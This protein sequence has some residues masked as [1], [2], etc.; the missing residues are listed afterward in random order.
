MIGSNAYNYINVLSKAADASWIRNEVIA[1]NIANNDTAD[2]KRQD[3]VFEL[4]T[5]AIPHARA[6]Q[7]NVIPS[8]R[9][10]KIKYELF[11]AKK[12]FYY[13]FAILY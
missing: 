10:A 6:P 5:A 11:S 1:N 2:Y 3:V 7:P 13:T 4:I 12:L 9:H 8:Y